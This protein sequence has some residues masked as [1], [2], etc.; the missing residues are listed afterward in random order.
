[1]FKLILLSR[2]QTGTVP[3][4]PSI[5]A[6]GAPGAGGLQVRE[7]IGRGAFRGLEAEWDALV[8]ETNDQPFY[9]HGFL[10]IWIDSFASDSE[11]RVLTGRDPSG[12]LAA[13][14]PLL[15]KRGR[16]HG[17]PARQLVS[18]SN[19]HS[20]RFDLLARDPEAASRA[21]L[22]HLAARPDWDLL[23][24]EDVPEGGDAFYLLSAAR[25]LGLPVGSWPSIRSPYLELPQS[26]QELQ[27]RLTSK[28]RSNL[29]R[30]RRKLEEK[31]RIA[32][33]HV[34]GEEGLEELLE[35]AF[36]IEALGWKG[37]QGSAIAQSGET[38]AFYRELARQAAHEGRLSLYF[39][40]LNGRA[41]AFHY[42]LEHRGTYFLLKPAYDEELSSFSPGQLLMEEVLKDC[43][44]RKLTRFDFLGPCMD[45]KLDWEPA[46][47]T[48]TWLTIFRPTRAGRLVHEARF[49]AW[50]V[51]RAFAGQ[52]RRALGRE[53]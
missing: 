47:R 41:V 3:A 36:R 9:R 7:V 15:E 37:K 50:P 48:H 23:H 10:R 24:I 43:I 25:E 1:M 42:A 6:T 38:L 16:I 39:L 18:A 30:R 32:L 27:G 35:E 29:R 19:H 20:C 2:G 34:S 45:W 49:T 4:L 53:G 5:T 52:L 28:F 13:A 8:E 40:K 31:G 12:A 44:R 26:Y 14:L 22:V 17:L 51:A 46:L 21:F 11:L 33:E